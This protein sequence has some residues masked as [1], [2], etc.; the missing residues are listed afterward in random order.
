VDVNEEIGEGKDV[1]LHVQ[2]TLPVVAERPMYF[3]YKDKW[4]GGHD[5][6]GVPGE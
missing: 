4:D 5:V 1:S 3:I 2:S 6:V